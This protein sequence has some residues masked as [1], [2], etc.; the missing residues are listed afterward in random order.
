MLKRVAAVHQYWVSA[1]SPTENCIYSLFMSDAY[2]H[3]LLEIESTVFCYMRGLVYVH[4]QKGFAS[5]QA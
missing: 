3:P 4:I 5:H 2:P 1:P